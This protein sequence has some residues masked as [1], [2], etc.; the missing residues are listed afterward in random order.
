MFSIVLTLG[1]ACETLLSLSTDLAFTGQLHPYRIMTEFLGPTFQLVEQ[2]NAEDLSKLGGFGARNNPILIK[3][4]V[5]AWPAWEKW[6]FDYLA[7]LRK[8]N[9][10]DAITEFQNG[11]VEQGKTNAYNVGPVSTYF[12]ELAEEAR[13]PQPIERGLLTAERYANLK[14]GETFHLDWSYMQSFT[15][16]K[17]YMSQ[18][19]ML[20]EFP[21]LRKDFKIR[22]LFPGMRWTWEYVFIGPAQTVTGV[23]HDFP[24][25]WFCQVRGSK[26]VMLF[27]PDQNP[28]MCK[29]TKFDWA[30]TPSRIDVT[31]LQGQPLESAKFAQAKG[32]YCRVE[33]G[34]ALFIPKRCWHTIVSLE[35]VSRIHGF[36]LACWP[37]RGT[38]NVSFLVHILGR[39]RLDTT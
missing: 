2:Y 4:A 14:P 28:H 33:A 3:G 9:G 31:N 12:A 19:E 20:Q 7:T 36:L 18:W 1:K 29:S 39:F 11:V 21:D 27:M 22:D 37:L 13:K 23:H 35:P 16:N 5:K 17:V 34:D 26:E 32:I 30:G 25:N 8:P 6:S 10:E 15:P 38:T 24:H